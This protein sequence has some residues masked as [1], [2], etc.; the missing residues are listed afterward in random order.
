LKALG[1]I[2]SLRSHLLT[3]AQL[4]Q[5]LILVYSAFVEAKKASIQTGNRVLVSLIL[6][7]F[8]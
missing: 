8:T 1:F 6:P 2:L 7:Y 5:N 3:P 4:F